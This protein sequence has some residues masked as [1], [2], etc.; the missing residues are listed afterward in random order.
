[1]SFTWSVLNNCKEN[2][3]DLRSLALGFYV[4]TVIN[5]VALQKGHSLQ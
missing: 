1:M 5:S 3:S 4:V 2:R